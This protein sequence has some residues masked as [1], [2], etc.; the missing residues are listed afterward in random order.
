MSRFARLHSSFFAN[1]IYEWTVFPWTLYYRN[2]RWQNRTGLLQPFSFSGCPLLENNAEKS[3]RRMTIKASLSNVHSWHI[4]AYCC[5][6]LI[7]VF[8]LFAWWSYTIEIQ[9]SANFST[10]NIILYKVIKQ[11]KQWN[12]IKD[13][14][15]RFLSRSLDAL[16]WRS[17]WK[18]SILPAKWK[19]G[20]FAFF[21][22]SF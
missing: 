11:I 22:N 19:G 4:L 10:G 12:Y 21:T 20:N 2:Q 17:F 14:G 3:N 9:T 8:F 6:Q 7:K 1:V 18:C 15:E 16:L 13:I 5:N